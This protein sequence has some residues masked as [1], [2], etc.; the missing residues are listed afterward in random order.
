MNIEEDLRPFIRTRAGWLRFTDS[1]VHEQL[2]A[3][4]NGREF[5]FETQMRTIGLRI[6]KL[7]MNN[8]HDHSMIKNASEN[9]ESRDQN[10]PQIIE[11]L[12][13]TRKTSMRASSSCVLKPIEQQSLRNKTNS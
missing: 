12:A 4:L 6:N 5:F 8:V 10:L 2:V 13:S 1:R 3:L 11:E 9:P 7:K